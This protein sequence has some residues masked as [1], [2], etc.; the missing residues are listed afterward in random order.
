[1]NV[2]VCYVQGLCSGEGNG[3]HSSILAWRV[4]RVAK[5]CKESDTTEQRIHTHVHTHT[6]THSRLVQGDLNILIH[7][8]LQMTYEVSYSISVL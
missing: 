2:I 1:M 3:S 5:G 6:H 4:P 8:L 7:L